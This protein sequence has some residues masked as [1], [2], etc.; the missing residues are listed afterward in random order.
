[1]AQPFQMAKKSQKENKNI[2]NLSYTKK[3]VITNLLK[4][5]TEDII[6]GDKSR[7]HNRM[8]LQKK[9]SVRVNSARPVMSLIQVERMNALFLH[10]NTPKV[11]YQSDQKKRASKNPLSLTTYL[12][13]L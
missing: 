8:Y 10:C 9:S 4:N 5:R 6:M 3:K 12:N 2:K 7:T 13:K 1:M 11:H